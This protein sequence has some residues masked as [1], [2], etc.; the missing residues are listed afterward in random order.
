V[1]RVCHDLHYDML[2]RMLHLMDRVS[3]V[4]DTS[5]FIL[6]V[7]EEKYITEA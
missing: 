3:S 7:G 4:R 2:D 5:K 1:G 6:S